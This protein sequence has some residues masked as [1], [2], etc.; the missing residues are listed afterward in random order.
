MGWLRSRWDYVSGILFVVLFVV[1]F[2]LTG[3]SGDSPAET[4]RFYTDSGN[5][6]KLFAAYFMF[7][8][9]MLAFLWFLGTLRSELYRAEGGNAPLTA[10]AFASGISFAVLMMAAMTFFT[11][12]AFMASDDNFQFDPN[13][14]DFILDAAYGLFVAA[15]VLAS[16]LPL[17]VALIAYRSRFI[18]L[19]VAWVS[20]PAGIALLFSIFFFPVIV[21]FVWVLLVS[22]VLLLRAWRPAQPSEPATA[23]P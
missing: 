13:T 22:I 20:V 12:P 11:T 9:A 10:V 6:A 1:G 7:L 16:L 19:W 5:Q 2:L 15:L 23:A 3:D 14:A 4:T 21:M 18:P 17:S 8:A